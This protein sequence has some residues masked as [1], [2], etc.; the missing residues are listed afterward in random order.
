[1]SSGP[2]VAV[3]AELTAGAPT[4]D[5][6]ARRTG[7]AR[8][9]VEAAVEQLVRMGRVTATTLSSACPDTGCGG[10]VTSGCVTSGGAAPGGGRPVLVA[11]TVR[12]G[13]ERRS[14]PAPPSASVTDCSIT[15]G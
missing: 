9:V 7:L 13:P 11:L 1:V 14:D 10:C 2:L 4:L 3:L 5:A 15:A 12:S 6:V 8:D